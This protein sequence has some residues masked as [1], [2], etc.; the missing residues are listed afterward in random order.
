M[1]KVNNHN[2]FDKRLSKPIVYRIKSTGEDF[3]L[4][5]ISDIKIGKSKIIFDTPNITALY[6]SKAE[7]ELLESKA[8]YSQI[9]VPKKSQRDTFNLTPEETILL[10]DYFEHIQT[11]IT[12]SFMS[13]ECLANNLIPDDYEYE[14]KKGETLKK[15]DIERWVST[16]DKL[17]IIL[18]KSLGI[19]NPK[20]YNFWPKFTKLRDLRNDIVHFVNV[21]PIE[22]KENERML[23]LLLN[24][25]VFGKVQSAFDLIRKI[26]SYLPPQN[27][28]PILK[29]KETIIPIESHDWDSLGFS[30]KE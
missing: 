29:S 25:S 27:S 8:L 18:P 22:A 21:L 30:R 14:N 3:T 1:D 13:V 7:R 23:S 16:T 11:S 15:K 17:T 19:P 4:K 6:L 28:M 26:H 24:D 2:M 9:I 20:S 12:L 10:F 5:E